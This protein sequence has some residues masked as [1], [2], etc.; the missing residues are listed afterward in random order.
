MQEI[1]FPI[2]NVAEISVYFDLYK[3]LSDAECE[4]CWNQMRSFYAQLTME[5]S[6]SIKF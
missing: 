3:F 5:P 2:F 1:Q 6:L 4:E